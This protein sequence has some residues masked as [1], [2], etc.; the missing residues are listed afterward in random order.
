[1]NSN[2]SKRETL[3]KEIDF[4]DPLSPDYV[5]PTPPFSPAGL[6]EVLAALQ[7][8]PQD[9]PERRATFEGARRAAFL[10]DRFWER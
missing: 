9:N 1:M 4:D 6:A 7:A 10:V 2:R 3:V 5:G 8:S